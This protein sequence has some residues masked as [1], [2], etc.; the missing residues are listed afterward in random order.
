MPLIE[1]ILNVADDGVGHPPEYPAPGYRINSNAMY[2]MTVELMDGRVTPIQVKNH[3]S[4]DTACRSELDA[5]IALAPTGTTT[6]ARLA[7]L[8][9]VNKIHAVCKLAEFGTPGYS[10]PA[11]LRSKLGLI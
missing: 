9:F 7:K 1:R 4:M 10:T 2:C 3:F 8:E 5:L 11:E 6:A